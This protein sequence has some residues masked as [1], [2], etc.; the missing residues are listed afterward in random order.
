MGGS[1]I[2]GLQK[3]VGPISLVFKSGWVLSRPHTMVPTPMST[4]NTNSLGVLEILDSLMHRDSLFND[5]RLDSEHF[6]IYSEL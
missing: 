1:N 4:H 3:W 2:I 5:S 6:R